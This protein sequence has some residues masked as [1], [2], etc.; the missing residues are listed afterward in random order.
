MEDEIYKSFTNPFELIQ[1]PI[2]CQSIVSAV[3]S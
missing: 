1:N 3:N 2:E